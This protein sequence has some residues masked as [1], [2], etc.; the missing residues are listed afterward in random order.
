[1]RAALEHAHVAQR[2]GV[3]VAPRAQRGLFVFDSRDCR[4]GRGLRRRDAVGVVAGGRI[5]RTAA[6]RL[7]SSGAGERVRRLV[8]RALRPC[9][10][11]VECGRF[12]LGALD[13]GEGIEL[14]CAREACFKRVDARRD[15]CRARFGVRVFRRG[16]SR[17]MFGF[18]SVR[19]GVFDGSAR[20]FE[21]RGVVFGG[22]QRRTRPFEGA[23]RGL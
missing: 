21:Q 15:A 16:R 5:D 9:G 14:A 19:I 6:G 7:F 13:G 12:L 17:S 20:V 18:G 4:I 23:A 8:E 22:L 10:V 3:G 11:A 2:R 1:M